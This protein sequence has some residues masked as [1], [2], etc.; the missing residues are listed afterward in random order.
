ML[1]SPIARCSGL[2]S[3]SSTIA[4]T[5]PAPSRTMRPSPEGSSGV[6]VSTASWSSSAAAASRDKVSGWMSG[7]SPIIATVTPSLGSCARAHFK[8]SPVPSSFSCLAQVRS[9]AGS[10]A[11]TS[12]PPLPKTTQIARGLIE[13]TALNK[14][15]SIGRPASRCKTFG[16]DERIRL[17]SPAAKIATWTG[18][19][20]GLGLS[21][22]CPSVALARNSIRLKSSLKTRQD[23][24]YRPRKSSA[25]RTIRAASQ[26]KRGDACPRRIL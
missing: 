16:R 18:I 23:V 11:G 9:V 10:A 12:S 20:M 2:A 21:H 24:H 3:F 5:W 7:M 14:C 25:A 19:F 1:I 22:F 4:R 17:P 6:A 8:A 15:A 26:P 13:R